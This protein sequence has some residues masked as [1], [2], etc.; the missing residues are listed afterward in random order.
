[1]ADL[2][3]TLERK[4]EEDDILA[5]FINYYT[6]LQWP[7]EAHRLNCTAMF[8]V[9]TNRAGVTSTLLSL[10]REGKLPDS[11]HRWKMWRECMVI[12]RKPLAVQQQR[13]DEIHLQKEKDIRNP[14]ANPNHP[15][16]FRDSPPE[17]M[18]DHKKHASYGVWNLED[19]VDGVCWDIDWVDMYVK[20]VDELISKEENK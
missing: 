16:I 12:K 18:V 14:I 1:M 8:S 4:K 19:R 13:L 5:V 3:A 2:A 7:T 9:F 11:D 10:Y 15:F 17:S 20:K 6:S